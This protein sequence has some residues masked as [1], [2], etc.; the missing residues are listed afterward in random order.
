MVKISAATAENRATMRPDS[1]THL[2]PKTFFCVINVCVIGPDKKIIPRQFS[3]VIASNSE[4][5]VCN[6]TGEF[7]VVAKK[8]KALF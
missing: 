2:I 8:F 4:L 6:W 7:F 5:F 3:C 1:I